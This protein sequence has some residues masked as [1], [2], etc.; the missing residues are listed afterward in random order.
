[1]ERQK[2]L[3]REIAQT[4]EEG[5]K[6]AIMGA[7]DGSQSLRQS[8]SGILRQ[9]G[10]QFLS[11]GIGSFGTAANP[12]GSGILGAI[13]GKRANGGTCPEMGLKN[14]KTRFQC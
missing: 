7:L 11:A 2:Q 10:G 3:A 9:L 1:M 5:I 14:S 8:L 12:A 6:G 13:F 4:I